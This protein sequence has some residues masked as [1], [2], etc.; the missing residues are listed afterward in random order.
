MLLVFITMTTEKPYKL[1]VKVK[2]PSGTVLF[3]QKTWFWNS[4]SKDLADAMDVYKDW[5][6]ELV[7][8]Y[9]Q[10]TVMDFIKKSL[11]SAQN[12]N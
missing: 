12:E 9:E 7:R 8:E 5:I 1:E 4:D 3:L 10:Q 11:I 2:T 6:Y